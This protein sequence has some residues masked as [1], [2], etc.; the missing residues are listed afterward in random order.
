ME[1]VIINHRSMKNECESL[2]CQ[3]DN[4]HHYATLSDEGSAP[5]HRLFVSD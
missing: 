3:S 5:A 4:G 1:Y 2:M